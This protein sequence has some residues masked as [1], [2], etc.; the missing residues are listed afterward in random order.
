MLADPMHHHFS[1]TGSYS[2]F[3]SILCWVMQRTRTAEEG[4]ADQLA[5]ALLQKLERQ[6][7]FLEPWLI[8]QSGIRNQSAASV[9]IG[10]RNALA[11]GDARSVKPYNYNDGSQINLVGFTFK[12]RCNYKSPPWEGEISLVAA[13]M[14]RMGTS[15]A[16]YF[17]NS[18]RRADRHQRD[19]HFGR[20]AATLVREE[21]A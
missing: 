10:L 7:I 1:V 13:D 19:N 16:D 8:H 4:Q 14:V 5:R 12:C 11:H 17:C 15:L 18:L 2:L 3:T 9:L 6:P 21:A 20:D